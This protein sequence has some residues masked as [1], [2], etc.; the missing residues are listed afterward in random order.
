MII[1]GINESPTNQQSNRLYQQYRHISELS[2]AR[3][4]FRFASEIR[5][6]SR[7]VRFHRSD[8]RS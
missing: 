1:T 3:I 5:H 8:F 7:D 2:A 6:R 4:D